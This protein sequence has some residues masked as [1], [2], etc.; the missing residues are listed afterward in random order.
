MISV[1]R[2]IEIRDPVH[3]Y[4]ELSELEKR[5][6]DTE[7]F[8]RLRYIKQLALA[9][10]VYPGAEHTRF[11]HSIGAMYLASIY[12]RHFME[13]GVLDE[14]DVALL[15]VSALL[16]DIGH[17]PFSHLYEELLIK[18]RGKTHEDIGS[19]IIEES[20]ISDILSEYGF[21]PK[22]VS[23]LAVGKYHVSDK[24]KLMSQIISGP[25]DADKMDFLLRDS[26]FTG[27]EYGRIDPY[28]L[29]SKSKYIDGVIAFRLPASLY[30]LEAFMIARYEMF[31]AVYFHKTVRAAELMLL[32]VLDGLKDELGILD[33]RSVEEYCRLTDYT[34]LAELRR[35]VKIPQLQG[36]QRK[37]LELASMLYRRDL[38]KC[39]FDKI[40][41]VSTP[42]NID[43]KV[44][45]KDLEREI[46]S[47]VGIDDIYVIVDIVGIPSLPYTSYL[48]EPMDI[49]VYEYCDDGI[50]L[51]YL[52]QYSTIA[53]VLR[54]FMNFIRVYTHGRFRN[55]VR[56]AAEKVLGEVISSLAL[57]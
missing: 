31:R 1:S 11:G 30:A 37:I 55:E 19:W 6:I 48:P 35:L 22:V 18:Y 33:F 25:V 12:G 42:Q 10:L 56:K 57:E 16:H 38:F 50:K 24:G 52:T 15:R 34:I 13:E 5:L 2:G 47:M 14:D 45:V 32:R 39:V 54:K 53:G 9:Y 21:E 8:Q 40:L 28:R 4:I 44:K 46:A 49:P 43:L 29:I 27:V 17:G 36:E 26:Y 23:K 3:G 7:V 20:E 51:G 41:H